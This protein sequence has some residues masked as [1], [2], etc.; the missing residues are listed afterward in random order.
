MQI[1]ELI[2]RLIDNCIIWIIR[3]IEYLRKKDIKM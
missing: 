1:D 2:D 3:Y